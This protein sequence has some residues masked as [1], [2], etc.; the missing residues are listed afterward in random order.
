MR[1]FSIYA[2]LS[3]CLFNPLYA[4]NISNNEIKR[5][6]EV[7]KSDSRGPYKEIRW[8]C[9]DGT[10]LPP[11][12]RC[13]EP[14]GVQRARHKDEVYALSLSNHIFL[15]QILATTPFPDFWDISNDH[16]RLKQYQLEKYLRATDNGWVLRRA[17]YYRGAIQAE[18]ETNWGLAFYY[19]L[20]A[21]KKAIEENYF[22]LRQSL[23]YIPHLGDSN[24][25]QNIRVVSKVIS[26]KYPP[27]LDLRVKIHGQPEE[28][29]LKKVMRF[30][31]NNQQQL[32]KELLDLFDKLISDMT[33]LYSPVDVSS[34]KVYLDQLPANSEFKKYVVASI[35][36]YSLAKQGQE[37]IAALSRILLGL[38]KGIPSVN[39][40]EA[41]LAVFDLSITLEVLLMKEL[42]GLSPESIKENL[43]TMNSLGMAS[44]GCGYMELWEWEQVSYHGQYPR[45]KGAKP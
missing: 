17:Q 38:R 11:Q 21:D 30:R 34:L 43:E 2:F 32:D 40:P 25:T 1:Y 10:I 41:R 31:D 7:Y 20:L 9:K 28:T 33:R 12:E 45:G 29:D 13:P 6:I 15:G 22:L 3:L 39:G 26:E 14:G 18:D 35:S 19:W 23:K 4:Q 27:F 24:L 5:R 8:Y 37:K 36:E 16:S 42:S 44:A